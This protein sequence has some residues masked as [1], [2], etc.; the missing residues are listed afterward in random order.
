[1]KTTL[2]KNLGAADWGSILQAGA[3]IFSSVSNS[4]STKLDNRS[5]EKQLQLQL[6]AQKEQ[7]EQNAKML[8]LL[9]VGGGVLVAG[10]TLIVFVSK[11]KDDQSLKGTAGKQKTKRRS[12]KK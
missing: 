9:L 7:S 4:R 10:I 3:S 2:S 8:K 12:K 1:M 5:A 6:Q 11:D